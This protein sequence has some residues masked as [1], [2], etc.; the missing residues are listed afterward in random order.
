MAHRL[1]FHFHCFD[2]MVL[3]YSQSWEYHHNNLE[4]KF[5]QIRQKKTL[6]S[7]P[8]VYF[9]TLPID[10]NWYTS[11]PMRLPVLDPYHSNICDSYEWLLSFSVFKLHLCC[12]MCQY[13]FILFY[14]QIIFPCVTI[15][16]IIIHPS[17]GGCLD[18][19]YYSLTIIWKNAAVIFHI[20]HI[21]FGG[22]VFFLG[23]EW[24]WVTRPVA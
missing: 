21:H 15:P 5:P 13:N 8:K 7:L 20:Q 6:F 12:S 23:V 14:C 18:Y 17:V 3:A 22:H 10:N 16:L 9:E 11:V 2:S 24:C 1:K 4:L 19:F